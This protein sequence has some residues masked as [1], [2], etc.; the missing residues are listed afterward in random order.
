MSY[1]LIIVFFTS[2]AVYHI[3]FGNQDACE[4][5]AVSVRAWR[6]EAARGNEVITPKIMAGCFPVGFGYYPVEDGV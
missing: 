1:L 2:P 6:D 4:H 5:A 3:P